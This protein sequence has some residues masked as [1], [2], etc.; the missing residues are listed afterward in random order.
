MLSLENRKRRWQLFVSGVF[1][2]SVSQTART[3]P[4]PRSIGNNFLLEIMPGIIEVRLKG[5][6]SHQFC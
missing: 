4:L 5:F 2:L 1:L 6:R 3:P